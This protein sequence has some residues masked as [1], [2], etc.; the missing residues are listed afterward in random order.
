MIVSLALWESLSP[1]AR[2]TA[3]ALGYRPAPRSGR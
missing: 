2:W 3:L 1:L